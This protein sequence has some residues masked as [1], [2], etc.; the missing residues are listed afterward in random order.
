M[1]PENVLKPHILSYSYTYIVKLV[2]LLFF[3]IAG[4]RTPASDSESGVSIYPPA[5]SLHCVFGFYSLVF[6]LFLF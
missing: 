1:S 6:V 3:R 2:N 5:S 4:L